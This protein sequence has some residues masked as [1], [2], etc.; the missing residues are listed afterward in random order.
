MIVN[1][2]RNCTLRKRY[3]TSSDDDERMEQVITKKRH[4]SWPPIQIYLLEP[5]RWPKVLCAR[6]PGFSLIWCKII[7]C[8]SPRTNFSLSQISVQLPVNSV[9]FVAI[10]LENINL[11]TAEKVRFQ[12][13]PKTPG[14]VQ[15]EV[16]VGDAGDLF[17]RLCQ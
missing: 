14:I 5:L 10:P 7:L 1:I 15:K 16:T 9:T 4:V 2:V 11:S 6:K 8:T 17:E 12:G 13:C 3:L